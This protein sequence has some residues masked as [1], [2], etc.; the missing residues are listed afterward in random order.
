MLISGLVNKIYHVAKR[1]DMPRVSYE[2][3]KPFEKFLTPTSETIKQ[4]VVFKGKVWTRLDQ[5]FVL[6]QRIKH[7]V[8]TGILYNNDA[9][10]KLLSKNITIIDKEL[11]LMKKSLHK[12]KFGPKDYQL[13]QQRLEEMKGCCLV[14]KSASANKTQLKQVDKFE[15]TIDLMKIEL[16]A[17]EPQILKE[18]NL[19]EKSISLLKN[20]KK[21]ITEH[22]KK[23][24]DNPEI[25]VNLTEG[26]PEISSP[27]KA[28]PGLEF[29]YSVYDAIG[30]RRFMEDAHSFT[31]IPQGIVTAVFDGHGGKAVAN[32][33]NDYLQKH[34][35]TVLKR[36]HGDV[37]Q[38]FEAIINEIHDEVCKKEQWNSIGSTAVIC[39]I[40]KKTNLIYTATLG[41][42]EAN[43]YRTING[44]LKSIPLSCVRDWSSQKDARRAAAALGVPEI[45]ERWPEAQDPKILRYPFPDCGVNVSRAIG[46]VASNIHDIPAISHKPKTTVNQILPGDLL[47]L[48]CDGLKDY[49]S[50]GEIVQVISETRETQKN[51]PEALVNYALQDRQGQDNVTVV[52]VEV[53]QKSIRRRPHAAAGRG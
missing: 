5:L 24:K 34:F 31:K 32:F 44:Q 4:Q 1:F 3:T 14:L 29:A 22:R 16:T 2:S 15:K 47:I 8:I 33:A 25:Y 39:F 12:G 35:A 41:D 36:K 20:T 49:V 17:L 28:V 27:L 23:E 30:P 18:K 6:W 51:I 52:S 10:I 13:N 9:T 50:E 53:G 21:A 48:A 26:V 46:D 19:L 42:S 37:R 40:D 7:F 11:S 45:A 43:I 38:A